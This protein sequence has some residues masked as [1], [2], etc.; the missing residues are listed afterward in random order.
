[1][2][3]RTTSVTSGD[4]LAETERS[5]VGGALGSLVVEVVVRTDTSVGE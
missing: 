5:R 3:C 4:T 2:A 1:M